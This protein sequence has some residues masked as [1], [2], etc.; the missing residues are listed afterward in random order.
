LAR[1]AHLTTLRPVSSLK[2]HFHERFT[3]VAKLTIHLVF[4]CAFCASAAGLGYLVEHFVFE[5]L[6]AGWGI[7][8]LWALRILLDLS[9]VATVAAVVAEDIIAIVKRIKKQIEE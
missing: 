7:V 4:D 6:E 1:R 3:V 9:L 2:D 8:V 5:K